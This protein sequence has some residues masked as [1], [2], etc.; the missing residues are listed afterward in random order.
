[1]HVNEMIWLEKRRI[2][3]STIGAAGFVNICRRQESTEVR[4][5]FHAESKLK[6]LINMHQ[7]ET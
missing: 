7:P 1:M 4:K 2:T 6:I 3:N 5:G